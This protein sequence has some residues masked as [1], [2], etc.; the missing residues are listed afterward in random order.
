[1]VSGGDDSA[2]YAAEFSFVVG[3]DNVIKI[4]VTREASR[5]SAHTSSVTGRSPTISHNW[6]AE[7]T[8]LLHRTKIA[9]SCQTY[10][11]LEVG[12]VWPGRVI[13]V[14]KTEAVLHLW[15]GWC[16]RPVVTFREFKK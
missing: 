11:A 4:D 3:N 12:N 7:S 15:T 9:A 6:L 16:D 8:C 1:M 14:F 13:A 10:S 2:L 5:A